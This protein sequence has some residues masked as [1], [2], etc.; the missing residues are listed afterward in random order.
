MFSY[1]SICSA[2]LLTSLSFCELHFSSITCAN[3]TAAN[4]KTY[5]CSLTHSVSQWRRRSPR[6]HHQLLFITALNE[7]A[8]QKSSQPCGLR[9]AQSSHLP[10]SRSEATAA[11][12]VPAIM[13]TRRA[14]NCACAGA[15]AT[16]TACGCAFVR[17][18]GVL[19]ATLPSDWSVVCLTYW[20]LLSTVK[21][22]IGIIILFKCFGG[23]WT[24]NFLGQCKQF[25]FILGCSL[26]IW[27]HQVT[28]TE[29]TS[30]IAYP[31]AFLFSMLFT[32]H[33]IF[34]CFSDFQSYVQFRTDI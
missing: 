11:A 21:Q 28:T 1:G 29:T 7:C 5:G 34:I 3:I 26:R 12:T 8:S 6:C 17:S 19:R 32:S 31:N 25:A 2:I 33:H 22:D 14:V 23:H 4:Y 13:S 15:A 10:G 27:V 16:T 30:L 9:P 20:H 24:R 18:C